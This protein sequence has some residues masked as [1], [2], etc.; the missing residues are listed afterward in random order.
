MPQTAITEVTPSLTAVTTPFSTVATAGLRLCHTTSLLLASAGNTVA[1]SFWFSPTCKLSDCLSSVML[2]TPICSPPPPVTVTIQLA[3]F[4]PQ[5][6]NTEVTP[7]LT[8]VTTPFS[9]VA[10]AGLRLCQTTSLLLASAGNTVAVSVCFP[11]TFKVKDDS[12]RVTSVTS[13][14]CCKAA[15]SSAHAAK[16]SERATVKI[17]ANMN[18]INLL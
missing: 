9:T 3:L 18:I 12:S 17:T 7:S 2:V 11:P 5:T 10:T 14:S 4:M 8:A 1:V 15:E 13:T 6:A 16:H